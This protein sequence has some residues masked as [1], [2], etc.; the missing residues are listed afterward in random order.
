MVLGNSTTK[1]EDSTKGSG[2][3]IKCR[4]LGNCIINQIGWPTKDNGLKI[5]FRVEVLFLTSIRRPLLPPLTTATSM[6]LRNT[7]SN[8]R[9]TLCR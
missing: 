3:I 2:N 8:M 6:I 7:G 4:A 9:V 5:S 1:T